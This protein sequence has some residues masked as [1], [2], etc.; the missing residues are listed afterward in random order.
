MIPVLG[1]PSQTEELIIGSNVI[2][3]LLALLRT[4]GATGS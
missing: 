4:T 1:V 2:K 3:L